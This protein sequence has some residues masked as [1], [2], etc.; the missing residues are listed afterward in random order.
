M[1]Q[2]LRELRCVLSSSISAGRALS[3]SWLQVWWLKTC[4]K[5]SHLVLIIGCR[6]VR[7]VYSW[8]MFNIFPERAHGQA[9]PKIYIYTMSLTKGLFSLWLTNDRVSALLIVALFASA[10]LFV[11]SASEKTQWEKREM[12]GAVPGSEFVHTLKTNTCI[13]VCACVHCFP[14]TPAKAVA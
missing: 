4:R 2:S 9:G 3:R 1:S 14:Y 8:S 6:F 5:T 10:S 7:L 11:V 13:C 12:E